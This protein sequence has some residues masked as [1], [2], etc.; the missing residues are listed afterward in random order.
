MYLADMKRDA[1]H[2]GIFFVCAGKSSILFFCGKWNNKLFKVLYDYLR[3][4]ILSLSYKR[5]T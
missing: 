4:K 2:L 3:G 1:H 5:E